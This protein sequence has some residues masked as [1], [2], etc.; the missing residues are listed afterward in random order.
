MGW[1][2]VYI[3]GKSGFE[4]EVL[5]NLEG[6]GFIFMPGFSA[7]KGLMLYWINEGEN[8][9]PFKNAIG[10]KTI[11]KYRLRFFTNIEEFVE[12]KY[13]AKNEESSSQKRASVIHEMNSWQ[14]AQND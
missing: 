4:A 5:N 8:L 10:S 2:T 6:S 13:N 7:E 11:L 1:I 14:E 3:R 12:S 9:R